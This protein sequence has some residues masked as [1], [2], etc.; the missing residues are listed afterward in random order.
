MNIQPADRL[1]LLGGMLKLQNDRLRQNVAVHLD[2]AHHRGHR[3]RRQCGVRNWILER[4]LFEVL[5]D[6]LLNSDLYGYR[7]FVRLSPELFRGLV[8]RVDPVMQK[9]K[10]RSREPLSSGLKV[11]ITLRILCT[12]SILKKENKI[13]VQNYN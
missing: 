2:L 5:M 10:A 7:H 9:E 6:Q 12:I 11:A 4:P 3:S 1:R 8:E 13:T